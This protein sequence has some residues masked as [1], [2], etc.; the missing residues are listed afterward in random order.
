MQ[1]NR[2]KTFERPETLPKIEIKNELHQNYFCIT[3]NAF[4][5]HSGYLKLQPDNPTWLYAV[6]VHQ[7]IV[8]SPVLQ[9]TQNEIRNE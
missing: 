2:K 6:R 7:K 5:R 4:T 9:I 3:K 8:I 1:S